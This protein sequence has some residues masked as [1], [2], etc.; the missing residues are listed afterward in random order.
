MRFHDKSVLTGQENKSIK[1]LS[2]KI[3]RN[4]IWHNRKFYMV[5]ELM[6]HTLR[7]SVKKTS[8]NLKIRNG[9][10]I[11]NRNFVW[12][13]VSTPSTTIKADNSK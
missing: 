4:H 5:W 11:N 1:I 9:A 13:R 6:Q 8:L 7:I 10:D 12:I 3:K 2:L